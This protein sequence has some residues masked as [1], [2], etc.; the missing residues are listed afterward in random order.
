MKGKKLRYLTWEFKDGCSQRMCMA[1]LIFNWKLVEAES[2][3]LKQSFE[4]REQ[5]FSEPLKCK[6][7]GMFFRGEMFMDASGN[8]SVGFTSITGTT[9][10]TWKRISNLQSSTRRG[11]ILD[12]KPTL[13][14]KWDKHQ[15]NIKVTAKCVSKFLNSVLCCGGKRSD[16]W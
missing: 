13:N 2:R 5:Q 7:L 15:L 11:M 8:V 6:N 3:I 14:F 9:A 4:Q 16:M 10:C 12:P 1:S